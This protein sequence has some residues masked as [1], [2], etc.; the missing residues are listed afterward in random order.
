MCSARQL[1]IVNKRPFWTLYF[2]IKQKTEWKQIM[3]QVRGNCETMDQIKITG[4]PQEPSNSL[5]VAYK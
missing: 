2:E 1:K 3:D 5:S 4:Y